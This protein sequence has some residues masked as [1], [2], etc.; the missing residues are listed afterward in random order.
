MRAP[1]HRLR[2]K[3]AETPYVARVSLLEG[4]VSPSD[5]PRTELAAIITERWYT[6]PGVQR[7]EIRHNGIVGTLFLPPGEHKV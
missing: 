1:L 4:H 2:K 7:T 3:D 6:A 5:V